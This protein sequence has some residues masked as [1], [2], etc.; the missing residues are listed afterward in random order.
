M[1]G[2][3]SSQTVRAGPFPWYYL[4]GGFGSNTELTE[5]GARSFVMFFLI[6]YAM[7][8]ATLF[9]SSNIIYLATAFLMRNDLEMYH[10][11]NDEPCQA[12]HPSAL[13]GTGLG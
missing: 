7:V 5:N 2:A 1:I 9:V 11:E 4:G 10:D 12:K 13:E 6:V 3:I 8:P